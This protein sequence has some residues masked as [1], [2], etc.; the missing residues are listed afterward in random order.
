MTDAPHVPVERID[1]RQADRLLD[2]VRVL[3]ISALLPGPLAAQILADL[4]AAVIKVERPPAGD[5]LR[6][7][8]PG[9]FES[10]N[11]NKRAV[12]LDL[13][14]DTDRAEL[15]RLARDADVVIEGFRPGVAARMGVD[16][17][18]LQQINPRLIHC[19]ISG[20]G[21]DGPRRLEAGH[22]VNYLGLAGALR[23]HVDGGS[24]DAEVLVPLGDV[25]A[26]VNA[27]A[28]ICAALTARE[29]TGRGAVI[30]LSIAECVLASMAPVFAEWDAARRS[31]RPLELVRRPAYGVFTASDGGALTIG[32]TETH[33]F[34]GLCDALGLDD[35]ATDPSLDDYDERQNRQR[36]IETRIA[37][38]IAQH[39][40]A[41]WVD[42]LGGEGLPVTAVNDV[43]DALAEPVFAR[44]DAVR[45]TPDGVQIGFPAVIDGHRPGYRIPVPVTPRG[46]E[47]ITWVE[48]ASAFV[49]SGRNALHSTSQADVPPGTD[50]AGFDDE[51]ARGVH[52]R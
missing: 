50:G 22:D 31:N 25:L 21:Q 36:E 43:A 51:G 6:S 42:R 8:L 33:F 23:P 46:G 13:K 15:H 17:N 19:A 44:H 45:E 26:A 41:H 38:V 2:G 49:P 35:L 1:R 39:P 34:R 30:D 16:P 40:A 48:A 9:M 29:R 20:Y 5:P 37:D 3:E 11:R 28:A 12:A 32:C 18:T 10:A 24:G 47:R 52:T 4:G 14:H 7:M 27:A